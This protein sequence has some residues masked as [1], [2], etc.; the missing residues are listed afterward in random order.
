MRFS[1]DDMASRMP[2]SFKFDESHRDFL[3]HL[4]FIFLCNGKYEKSIDIY[5]LLDYLFPSDFHIIYPLAYSHIHAGSSEIALERLK[6]LKG[7]KEF[8]PVFWFLRGQ[9]FYRLS[10]AAEASQAMRT[11][12]RIKNLDQKGDTC[13]WS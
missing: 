2:V 6:S 12:I 9:A 13:S 5:S 11:C 1:K 7:L 8:D 3:I 10:L 4:A